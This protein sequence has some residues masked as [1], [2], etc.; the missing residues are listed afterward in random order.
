MT[1]RQNAL[2]H[3]QTHRT[4]T[5]VGRRRAR[6]RAPQGRSERRTGRIC[7]R[8]VA[9][10]GVLCRAGHRSR[11]YTDAQDTGCTHQQAGDDHGV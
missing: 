11:T 9:L 3:A 5:P 6:S 1:T 8:A 10:S 7:A 2:R 4:P